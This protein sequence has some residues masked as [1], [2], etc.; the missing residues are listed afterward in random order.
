MERLRRPRPRKS[1]AIEAARDAVLLCRA[2]S[3]FAARAPSDV[4][5]S[6]LAIASLLPS[7][8]K[9]T[10]PKPSCRALP[11][12]QQLD[13]ANALAVLIYKYYRGA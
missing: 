13:Y 1:P 10:S 6:L 8:L 12:T 3:E 2:L 5:A 4:D 9:K 11:P 7:E